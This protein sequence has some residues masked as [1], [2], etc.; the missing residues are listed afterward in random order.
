[1][2]QEQEK[3]ER[4]REQCYPNRAKLFIQ[5]L[6]EIGDFK[7]SGAGSLLYAPEAK[8]RGSSAR[9]GDVSVCGHGESSGT[10]YFFCIA[11]SIFGITAR[12]EG[13]YE[14]FGS[15]FR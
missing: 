13:A 11:A 10:G 2:N 3:R 12:T 14:P 1:M 4:I 15:S 6:R 9:E 5:G 7:S 8:V